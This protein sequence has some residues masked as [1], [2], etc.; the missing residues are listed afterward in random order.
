MVSSRGLGDVYKRQV[1]KNAVAFRWAFLLAL[2]TSV[3]WSARTVLANQVWLA[4]A[5]PLLNASPGQSVDLGW[6]VPTAVT[7]LIGVAIDFAQRK[8]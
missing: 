8:N 2:W 6:F 5:E 3:V 7:A 1:V 4:A